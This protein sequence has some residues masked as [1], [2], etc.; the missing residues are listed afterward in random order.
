MGET[1]VTVTQKGGTVVEVGEVIARLRC[2]ES[3]A[4][5]LAEGAEARELWYLELSTSGAFF[6]GGC[7]PF[8]DGG[9][10]VGS[11]VVRVGV[12]VAET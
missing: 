12:G 2:R 9:C 8:R 10:E 1:V 7:T 4:G 3:L 11:S 5:G 6:V